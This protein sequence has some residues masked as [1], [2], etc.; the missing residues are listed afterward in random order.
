M[1]VRITWNLLRNYQ[2]R[3]TVTILFVTF[4][5]IFPLH[6]S[7][8]SIEEKTILTF[9][10]WCD[11]I[12]RFTIYKHI[13][14]TSSFA[15]S[16]GVCAVVSKRSKIT[17]WQC[18]KENFSGS[19]CI[20]LRDNTPYHITSIHTTHVYV[21]YKTSKNL[22]IKH[23]QLSN[24]YGKCVIW[25]TKKKCVTIETDLGIQ[26]SVIL[27][28][29]MCATMINWTQARANG[30]KALSVCHDLN[31]SLHFIFE[32][33]MCVCV[34]EHLLHNIVSIHSLTLAN[35]PE[36]EIVPINYMS[37]YVMCFVNFC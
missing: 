23:Y 15:K 6:R 2:N 36:T 12:E 24:V 37:I 7:P 19:V 16:V 34:C 22:C 17:K 31:Q 13:Q 1:S 20:Q 29:S 32:N 21:A 30:Q 27:C 28:A 9:S 33:K 14:Y 3:R 8:S 10:L 5:V 11:F 4:C 18:D 25:D 35:Y 26:M